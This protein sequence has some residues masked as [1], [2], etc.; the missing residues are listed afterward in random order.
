MAIAY[1][2][3]H[4][5]SFGSNIP[6]RRAGLPGEGASSFVRAARDVSYISGQT[7]YPNDGQV[8]KA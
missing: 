7:L 2:D 3:E 5:A 4:V 8:V 1:L 6:L